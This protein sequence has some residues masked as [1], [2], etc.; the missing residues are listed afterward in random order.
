MN[1]PYH[2]ESKYHLYFIRFVGLLIVVSL[3]VSVNSS[4]VDGFVVSTGISREV[5]ISNAK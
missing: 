5:V 4:I 1:G 3:V 2:P